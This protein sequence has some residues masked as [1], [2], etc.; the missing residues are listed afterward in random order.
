[1]TEQN[2]MVPK[3]AM[4]YVMITVEPGREHEAHSIIGLK[5][6]MEVYPVTGENCYMLA[7]VEAENQDQLSKVVLEKI[8]TIPGVVHTESL[9]RDNGFYQQK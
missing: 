9:I 8:R 6:V 1:M 3:G 2:R 7:I 4:A 5:E